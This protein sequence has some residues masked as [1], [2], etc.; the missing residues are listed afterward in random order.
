MASQHGAH[1]LDLATSMLSDTII[2]SAMQIAVFLA[3]EPQQRAGSL[4]KWC[5]AGSLTLA[6]FLAGV[7]VWSPLLCAVALA[8]LQPTKAEIEQQQEEAVKQVGCGSGIEL[9]SLQQKCAIATQ[10][11]IQSGPAGRGPCQD[12]LGWRFCV[13]EAS[14]S[15]SLCACRCSVTCFAVAAV[16][17]YQAVVTA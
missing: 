1:G 7:L 16:I 12:M 4:V 2:R 5:G 9:L 10:G 13:D 6:C 17:C 8:V 15:S 3:C 11:S 14:S